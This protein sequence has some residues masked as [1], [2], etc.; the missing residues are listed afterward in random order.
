MFEEVSGISTTG[1]VTFFNISGDVNSDTIKENDIL[2]IGTEKIKVL[3]LDKEL[4]RIRVIRQYDSTVG[5]SHTA[6]SLISQKPRSFIFT[7]IEGSQN[8]NFRINKELYFNPKESVALGNISGVGIG[9]TL[10]FSNPGA[11]ISEIFIPTKSIYF[12]NHGLKSGDSLTYRT[13][14]EQP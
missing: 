3:N 2:G 14:Q 6:N 1:I 11:G 8:S 12:K 10:F 4:S 7:P 9:S 5:S 13:N